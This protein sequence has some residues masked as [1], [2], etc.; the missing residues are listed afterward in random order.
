VASF[1]KNEQQDVTRVPDDLEFI[2]VLNV[3]VGS[4]EQLELAVSQDETPKSIAASRNLQDSG[5]R[6]V[7]PSHPEIPLQQ[8]ENMVSSA[9]PNQ[10]TMIAYPLED[11][12]RWK[13]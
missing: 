6:R 9:P 7:T 4:S 12:L 2:E 11:T 8:L 3:P 10:Y 1:L 13:R 5:L